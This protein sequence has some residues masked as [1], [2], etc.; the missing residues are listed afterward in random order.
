MREA[1]A[2]QGE[3]DTRDLST[4]LL[5]R[6]SKFEM[7]K[8][9]QHSEDGGRHFPCD[10]PGCLRNL[11]LVCSAFAFPRLGRDA[12]TMFGGDVMR[13]QTPDLNASPSTF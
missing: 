8:L 4:V 9:T 1:V 5:T 10:V 12:G 6:Q 3:G 7:H 2:Q 13:P 11:R